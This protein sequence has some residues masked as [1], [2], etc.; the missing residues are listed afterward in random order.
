MLWG[1]GGTGRALRKALAARGSEPSHI[2]EVHPRRLGEVIHG[3]PVIRPEELP[4]LQ[5]A[6]GP[7]RVI[8]SVAGAGPRALIRASLDA[9][10]F[11]EGSDY[12]C[13]A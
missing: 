1:Y 9:M 3:A 4:A 11:C 7:L 8:A 2:V 5:R 6:E 10:G 12:V 13:A